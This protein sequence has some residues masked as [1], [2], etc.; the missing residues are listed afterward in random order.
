MPV[1][2]VDRLSGRRGGGVGCTLFVEG[3]CDRFGQ[4]SESGCER[5]AELEVPGE[6]VGVITVGATPGP[7]AKDNVHVAVADLV[8]L[9][10]RLHGSPPPRAVTRL[11][12]WLKPNLIMHLPGRLWPFLGVTGKEMVLEGGSGNPFRAR[13]QSRRPVQVR[14]M[15][16]GL[17]TALSEVTRLARVA[18]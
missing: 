14:K 3:G 13:K 10:L 15:R 16:S 12:P 5:L 11:L 4:R 18:F 17:T 9:N 1:P 7:T 2:A 8:D 6:N